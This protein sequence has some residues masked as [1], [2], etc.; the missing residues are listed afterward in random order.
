M[1]LYLVQ[2]GKIDESA[3]WR[4]FVQAKGLEAGTRGARCCGES[5]RSCADHDD[6]KR[7]DTHALTNLCSLGKCK[8]LDGAKPY[9]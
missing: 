5:G 7:C 1:A 9:T 2:L 4:E 8:R 6:V 3:A